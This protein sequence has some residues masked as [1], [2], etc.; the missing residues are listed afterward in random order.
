MRRSLR[1]VEPQATEATP[2]SSPRS[3]TCTRSTPARAAAAP[4]AARAPQ[5]ATA[6]SSLSQRPECAARRPAS[7]EPRSRHH[8]DERAT[9]S[10]WRRRR[11]LATSCDPGRLMAR[12]GSARQHARELGEAG[13]DRDR[14]DAGDRAS[15]ERAR[16]H[17]LE[18]RNRIQEQ[19]PVPEAR[20]GR[21][22][23]DQARLEEVCGEEDPREEG[24]VSLRSARVRGDR[25][26]QARRGS[27]RR[28]PGARGTPPTPSTF[29]LRRRAARRDRR[30][31]A[32]PSSGVGAGASAARSIHSIA[33][34]GSP[35]RS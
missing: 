9:T 25:C 29:R 3:R 35:R 8:R 19:I 7:S 13:D 5:S 22:D 17:L 27:R 12:S 31:A 30:A 20:P 6:T 14:S 21:H 32:R 23:E 15:G 2:S 4:R 26:G 16:E 1:E 34:A 33:S 28:R 24:D 10:D 11:A 18:R